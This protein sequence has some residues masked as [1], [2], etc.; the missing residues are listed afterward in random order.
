MDPVDV[1]GP[2]H[3]ITVGP[4]DLGGAADAV[5]QL[6]RSVLPE[7]AEVSVAVLRGTQ[8]HTVAATG[9]VA[10]FLDGWQYRTGQ[11][12]CL[13]A[14]A[15]TATVYAADLRTETRW[16][17]WLRHGVDV[18]ARSVLSL[19][20]GIDDAVSGAL[21]V[22]TAQ[23]NAFPGDM[24]DLPQSLAAYATATL[25]AVHQ[26][27][28]QAAHLR[29]LQAAMVHR[30]AIEQAKGI[31][32]GDRR[33]SPDEA[34]AILAKISQDTNRKLH[35]VAAAL[36]HR[37]TTTLRPTSAPAPLARR[38]GA[39]A[40]VRHPG[41]SASAPIAANTP[42]GTDE[43]PMTPLRITTDVDQRGVAT[44]GVV[45]ELVMDTADELLTKI[46]TTLGADHVTRVVVDLSR[47]SFL[48]MVALSALLRGRAAA[49]RA[50]ASFR[51]VR[52]Q[53]L[54]RRVLHLT[55]TDQ[56]LTAR[57]TAVG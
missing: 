28:R 37:A 53:P 4:A 41:R 35:D 14:V 46:T 20:L 49:L 29:D 19:G 34:F 55:G 43:A 56:I 30:A 31:I 36:V 54:V 33:C 22:Y 21:T 6:T 9:G 25:K 51:A 23:P 3:R 45:G 57:P 52:P 27:D 26:Y 13:Q 32:M 42:P 15:S 40:T 39:A 17:R 18:G 8:V 10:R 50:G 24:V 12:P 5:V 47:V 11:G 48:D 1:R 44:I 2:V 7:G 38:P 16:P